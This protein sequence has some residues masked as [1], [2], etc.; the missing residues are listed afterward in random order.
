ML[1]PDLFAHA[2]G[3]DLKSLQN[4]MLDTHA[5]DALHRRRKGMLESNT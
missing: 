5:E 1:S 4:S 3:C 2:I